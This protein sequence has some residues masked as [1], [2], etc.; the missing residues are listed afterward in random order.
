M[1]RTFVVVLLLG[2]VCFGRAAA[3]SLAVPLVATPPSLDPRSSAGSWP[4]T[5]SATLAW[6]VQHSRSMREATA[7][8]V[9]TD[10]RYLYVRF[11]ATQSEPIVATQRT[12]D[13][14]QGTDDEVWVDL[15]PGGANGYFYQFAATPRGTHYQSSSENS[16]YAP[17]WD[18]YGAERAGG[19]TVV[20]KIPL[21][22]MRVAADSRHWRIQFVRYVR[23]D[24]D[25]AVWS[26]NAT[27]TSPDDVARAGGLVL[28]ML[29][30]ARPKPRLATY[31]LAS[32]AGSSAGG[33]TTRMGADL[34]IP[35]TP[36]S[37]FYATF[38]P[39]YSN[40]ELDQQSIAPSAFAR[41]Y[42]EVRPFFTQGSN[43]FNPF[44]CDACPGINE[45][46]TPAIPTPRD[47]YAMEGKQG[48]VGY[49]FLD[50]R[51]NAR[52]DQ[53]EAMTYN[54]PDL[55]WNVGAQ[56]VGVDL[57]GLHDV[58]TTTGVS[59]SDL[60]HVSV[61][62]NYGSDTGTNVLDGGDA[63]RYDAGGGWSSSNFGFFASMRKVGA[64]YNPVDG[65]VQH[66][67]IAGYALYSQKVWTPENRSVV[68]AIGLGGFLD[69][70][71]ASD[72]AIDQSDN[73]LN[74]DILTRSL[75]DLNLT[76]GSAYL[77]V[78]NIGPIV[79][80]S[81]NGIS[82]TYH[83][84][85]QTN[86]I[87][88][89]GQHGA[90]ATPTTISYN[91]GRY[92]SGRLDTWLRS[93]TLRLGMRGTLTLELDD[94]AQRFEAANDRVQWFERVGYAYLLGPHTSIAVGVRR[95][96]GMPPVPNGGGNCEGVCSNI[97]FA[98]HTR[99]RH[100]EVYFAYGNPNSLSTVPQLL[101]KMIFYAGADKGT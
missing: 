53:V 80:I 38:H 35:V 39:D 29:D 79:P 55:R 37:S 84:G 47:G 83:S 31:V 52:N 60:R 24:G 65:F 13:V 49:T 10:G 67:G 46:Y 25:E 74:V 5:S 44:S 95:V 57:P 4:A 22:I 11:D 41:Y 26:Y 56:R 33:A 96:V 9:A 28:P 97:S 43:N 70:Y 19:Y 98:Y 68:K 87:G 63:Q 85:S 30:A 78:N 18:S 90:S 34:S 8:H 64:Y 81:Q 21:R 20:M 6:D 59:Y 17:R 48:P 51:G 54:T 89:F 94:T 75:L 101:F 82:F 76:T 2:A 58:V 72:G 66:P 100:A 42:G 1:P 71:H 69:R 91:T 40:V 14:G 23:Q 27:Q 73:T 61:Y 7:V 99:L 62:A 32:A 86:N 15:W 92:G 50:A 45:L 88:N 36:T 93:S 16:A 12:D 3:S 77:Q